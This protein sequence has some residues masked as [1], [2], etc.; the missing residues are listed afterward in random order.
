M[1]T[2]DTIN[3]NL[4]ELLSVT[5]LSD[6]RMAVWAHKKSR[7]GAC[8]RVAL[9]TVATDA[10]DGEEEATFRAALLTPQPGSPA[11]AEQV[12]AARRAGAQAGSNDVTGG[13]DAAPRAWHRMNSDTE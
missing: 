3:A 11:A 7:K 6:G 9:Y 10:Y 2:L 12:R 8:S 4:P 5:E 1:N 13:H